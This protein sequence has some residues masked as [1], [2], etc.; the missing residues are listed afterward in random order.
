MFQKA[1]PICALQI[2]VQS[3]QTLPK[4]GWKTNSQQ[5]SETIN[6]LL[7]ERVRGKHTPNS[8]DSPLHIDVP[9]QKDPKYF[10]E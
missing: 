7:T 3:E 10:H 2:L 1:F 9:D 4:K 8:V 5:P 6:R